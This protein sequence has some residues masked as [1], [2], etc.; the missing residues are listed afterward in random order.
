MPVSIGWCR[1]AARGHALGGHPESPGRIEALEEIERGHMAGKLEQV[2]PLIPPAELLLQVHTDE[3]LASLERASRH[4]PVLLDS[5]DTFVLAESWVAAQQAA[6]A[7]VAITD[8]VLKHPGG[9]GFSAAR[10]PGHHAT[11]SRAMGFCLLNNV[12]IAARFALGQGVDRVLIV[13]FDVHHGNGTQDIFADDPAVFY[14][15]LHQRLLFPGTGHLAETGTGPGLGT[16]LNVPL[17]AGTNDDGYLRLLDELLPRV[18]ARFQPQLVLASAGYD[19]HWLDPLAR[20]RLSAHGYYHITDRL[21]SIARDYANG[22]LAF[23]LEG[24][25]EPDALRRSV[26]ATL[27][28]LLDQPPPSGENTSA[29]QPAPDV[30]QLLDQVLDLHF[31]RESDR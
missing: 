6:G 31:G 3:L 12:A 23:I 28:A 9:Y 19:A 14:L 7:A 22:R 13:D 21:R 8:Y 11:R 1:L 15:S 29:E 30:S 18:A 24:G 16:V 20:L 25:Y 10:P 27:A 5:G 2:P 17:P 26:A 4:G